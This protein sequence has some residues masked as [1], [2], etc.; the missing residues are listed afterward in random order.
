MNIDLIANTPSNKAVNEYVEG[1]H[2]GSVLRALAACRHVL[3][4]I[5]QIEDPEMRLRLYVQIA[6]SL[7]PEQ[8]LAKIRR[9]ADRNAKRMLKG[10]G[11]EAT[12]K[13]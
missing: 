5:E 8:Q 13:L 6:L 1:M 7:A 12:R 4:N 10:N 3:D 11:F 9:R 2:Y